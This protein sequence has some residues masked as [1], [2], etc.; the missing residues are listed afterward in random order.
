MSEYGSGAFHVHYVGDD[1]TEYRKAYTSWNQAEKARCFLEALGIFPE[2]DMHTK[3]KEWG[4][5]EGEK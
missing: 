2:I 3:K 1:G 5:P 4:N